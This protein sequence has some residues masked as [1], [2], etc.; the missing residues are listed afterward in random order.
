MKRFLGFLAAFA[1][2]GAGFVAPV[3]ADE[4]DIA[5]HILD[6]PSP[7]FV[8]TE[9][10]YTN[11]TFWGLNS[12]FGINVPGALEVTQGSRDVVVGIIDTGI[13]SHSDLN[14]NV[15][16][17]YDFVTNTVYAGDGGGRDSNPAD[18]GDYYT[19]ADGFHASSWHGTHVAGIIGALA[20]GSGAVGVSPNI[21][22]M[23]VRALGRGG[24]LLADVND[25]ITW[26]S[27]GTVS[28]TPSVA[29]RADVINLSLGK[30][31]SVLGT[32]CPA[33]VQSAIDGAVARGTVVVVAAGNGV[34]TDTGGGNF[35]YVGEDLV[36]TF[37]ANCQNV[38][39]VMASDSNGTRTSWS[40]YVVSPVSNSVYVSAPGLSIYSTFNT[41]SRGPLAETY[42]Y[43]SGTS[44]ATP[45]V[46]G[47]IA[48]IRA[49]KPGATVEE[50]KNLFR[51][52]QNFIIGSGDVRIVNAAKLVQAASGIS[53][54]QVTT[55]SAPT[56]A[57]TSPAPVI[58]PAPVID[59]IFAPAPLT[60]AK[61]KKF[62]GK[63]FAAQSGIEV[64]AKSTV[65]LKV[66]SGKK[67]C[68]IKSG[69]LA[70]LKAGTCSVA[71][72]VKTKVKVGKKY[73]YTTKTT[74][75][76]LVVA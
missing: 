32:P 74:T 38:I 55:E 15:I 67:I 21:S 36:N 53:V 29:K 44:M 58:A 26:A 70:T 72:K 75:V 23:P 71:V 6:S 47:V 22:I 27:G 10:G 63:N 54:T 39:V 69:K 49:I 34:L 40:N 2:F 61:K 43:S 31:N 41:G 19:D 56:A 33:D 73:K 12:T 18:P 14:A 37:P 24:G 8:P 17:G 57:T 20:N 64:P 76:S 62:T 45:F 59:P 65:T 28:G 1:I 25:A 30:R 4:Q 60:I 11:G 50:I 48:L 68:T 52:P 3:P 7:K 66:K 42:A 46:V 5:V 13:T 51:D 9:P 16:T 35:A